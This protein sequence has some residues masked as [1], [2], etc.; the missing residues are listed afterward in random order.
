[1]RIISFIAILTGFIGFVTGCDLRQAAERL[2]PPVIIDTSAPRRVGR[3]QILTARVE[4]ST[5]WEI[6]DVYV[7]H[8]RHFRPGP[9]EAHESRAQRNGPVGTTAFL[10][11]PDEAIGAP[12]ADHISI[13]GLSTIA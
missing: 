3:M 13:S 9:A 12:T 2:N 5:A 8:T 1:M 7:R 6:D 10:A 4:T 11:V